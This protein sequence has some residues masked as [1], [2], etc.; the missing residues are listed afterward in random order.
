MKVL[1]I[2]EIGLPINFPLCRLD[3]YVSIGQYLPILDFFVYYWEKEF[4][5]A[6][7]RF[8]YRSNKQI[9]ETD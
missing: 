9:H 1:F 6:F 7:P 5:S 2:L 4:S 3:Y 8:F